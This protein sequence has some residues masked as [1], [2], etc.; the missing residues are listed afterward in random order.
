MKT[1]FLTTSLLIFFNSPSFAY[2]FCSEENLVH[3]CHVESYDCNKPTHYTCHRCVCPAKP[4]WNSNFDLSKGQ[5]E[6]PPATFSNNL[7]T[8]CE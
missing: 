6:T 2:D 8:S 7:P 4:D 5:F 3:G 1:I